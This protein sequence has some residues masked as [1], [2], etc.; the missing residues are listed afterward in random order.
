MLD[1]SPA[2][3]LWRLAPGWI[4]SVEDDASAGEV[5]MAEGVIERVSHYILDGSDQDL[6]RLLSIAERQA[7]TARTAFPA[8]AVPHLSS[9]AAPVPFMTIYPI[10]F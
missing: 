5:G 9:V 7:E 3:S 1:L 4:G 2:L 6:R 8:V 10:A